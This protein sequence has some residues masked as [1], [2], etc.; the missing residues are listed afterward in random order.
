MTHMTEGGKVI[1]FASGCDLPL[2]EEM[3]K[4]TEE[5][6]RNIGMI[7]KNIPTEKKNYGKRASLF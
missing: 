6:T 5:D 2:N 1:L 4:L 7:F 3:K